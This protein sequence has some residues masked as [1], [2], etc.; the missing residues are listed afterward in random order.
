MSRYDGL[1][2]PRSYSEYIN[3]TDA[4]TLSQALQ[5]GGVLDSA[6]TEDSTN[7]VKSGGIYTALKDLTDTKII[8]ATDANEC[9]PTKGYVATYFIPETTVASNCPTSDGINYFI[10]SYI[11]ILNNNVRLV[12]M[13]LS[14]GGDNPNI[15]Y[16]RTARKNSAE[17]WVFG[18]WEK[19]PTL[20][21][22]SL[23]STV[24]AD[25]TGTSEK[26]LTIEFT[27]YAQ[28]LAFI[29]NSN[30]EI[31]GTAFITPAQ[32]ITY[33]ALYI[34][35]GSTSVWGRIKK[36][37]NPNELSF[38]RTSATTTRVKLLGFKQG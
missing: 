23:T 6:P 17:A 13:A 3:K 29:T 5:L 30:D 24:L 10:I 26:V 4:A 36:T 35:G 16:K 19:I 31:I 12:Q 32:L 22:V 11:Q 2:I 9:R 7:P 34:Y 15:L 37:S 28:L 18:S 21:E 8:N 38:N 25:F 27:A 1:I 14:N 33:G 20:N